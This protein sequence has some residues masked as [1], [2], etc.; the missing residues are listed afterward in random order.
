MVYIIKISNFNFLKIPV[1]HCVALII[2]PFVIN[3][4]TFDRKSNSLKGPGSALPNIIVVVADDLGY[5]DLACFGHPEIK[6][7]NLD[8]LAKEGVKL[9][10]CY[11]ASAVCSPSRA[12]IM[13]GKNPYKVGVYSQIPMMNPMHLPTNELTLPSVL[14]NVGY[15]TC[16]VG[17]WHLNG[18]FNLPGQPQPDSLGFDYWFATQN[19]ALPNHRNPYNFVRNGIPQGRMNGYSAH[20]VANEAVNWLQNKWD[21]SNPFFLYVAF[22]EPHEPIA[23][24]IDYQSPYIENHP[25]DP[26]R[27]AYYG[28]VTQMDAAMGQ[29]LD[30][31]DSMGLAANTLIWFTSDNGP[32]RT[33]WHNAGSTKGLRGFKGYLYE[34]GIRVPGIIRWPQ[35]IEPGLVSDEIVSGI[36][37]FQTICDVVGIPLPGNLELDGT[38]IFPLFSQQKINRNKPL[39][40]KFLWARSEPKFALMYEQWKLLA[41]LDASELPSK[42]GLTQKDMELIKKAGFHGFELYD[43][44]NDPYEERNLAKSHENKVKE[45][46]ALMDKIHAEVQSE[47]RIWSPWNYTVYDASRIEWPPYKALPLKESD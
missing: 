41:R 42:R 11:S 2:F 31:L 5:G 22:H 17:K 16:M 25:N 18:L 13:T 33:K 23:T 28:N 36:D 3:A 1:I 14:S 12:A 26:S 24:D 19:V 37:I 6:T 15:A 7:P 47:S 45:L 27:A 4:N 39:F 43:I 44:K 29:I 9:L 10:R 8:R 32:A 40:W 21:K 20:I 30:K 35:G 34:G 46:V 38:S